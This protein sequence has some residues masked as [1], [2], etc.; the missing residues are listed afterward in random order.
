MRSVYEI[1]VEFLD[2]I[3]NIVDTDWTNGSFL[4]VI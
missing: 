4:I 1:V 3:E 2:A